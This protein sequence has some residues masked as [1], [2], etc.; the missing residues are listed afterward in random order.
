MAAELV[1][2][3][4]GLVF[5][6]GADFDFA[7]ARTALAVQWHPALSGEPGHA[8]IFEGL[9]AEVRLHAT[10]RSTPAAQG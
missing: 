3:V 5:S 9:V 10:R 4:D 6:S 7:L 1:G 8:R 2:R